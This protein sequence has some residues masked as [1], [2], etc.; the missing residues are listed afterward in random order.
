SEPPR[1]GGELYIA[2][3]SLARGYLKRPDL[4]RERFIANPYAQKAGARMYKTGDLVRYLP[5]GNIEFIGR[6][7]DQVSIRGFRVE[8][9]EIET[10]LYSHP[11]VKET[12]VLVRED[13]PGMKRL[14]AYIVQREGQE[15][16]AVQAGDFRSY[17]KEML[18]EYMVPAAFVFMAGL[19]L[20]PN[21][22]VDR[23]ALPAPDLFHSEADGTYVA[24]ATE[25]ELKLAHIWK[26][27]LGLAD[28]GIHDNFFEL[29][30]DS[31]LSIQ[32]VSRANQ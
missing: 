18:P 32:I 12:I 1:R 16:Q 13:M 20:T 6:A 15:G 4:T 26:N 2:G 10:A 9:G 25:L 28:V 17:L 11:A 8:L 24:P 31:I 23:R 19:P 30:G 7:D 3:D 22:K 5:D 14:V 29:G 27:V 21:G